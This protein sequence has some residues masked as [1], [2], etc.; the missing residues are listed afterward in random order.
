MNP[1]TSFFSHTELLE[2]FKNVFSDVVDIGLARIKGASCQLLVGLNPLCLFDPYLI[3]SK[4]CW[5]YV[6]CVQIVKDNTEMG[7]KFKH[8]RDTIQ[9]AVSSSFMFKF[10]ICANESNINVC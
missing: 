7:S 10:L 5:H 6:T 4:Q 3:V 8:N 2:L 1:F 9:D